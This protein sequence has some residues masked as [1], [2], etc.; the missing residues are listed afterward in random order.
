MP[1]IPAAIPGKRA[2]S[3]PVAPELIAFTNR[4]VLN[5]DI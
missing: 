2:R 5:G 3:N 1:K 4:V